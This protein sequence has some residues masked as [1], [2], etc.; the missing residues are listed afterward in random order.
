MTEDLIGVLAAALERTTHELNTL[1]D[2]TESTQDRAGKLLAHARTGVDADAKLPEQLEQ[3][4]DELAAWQL[5]DARIVGARTRA[6]ARAAL[7]DV[8]AA[9]VKRARAS[10]KGLRA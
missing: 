10:H 2:M 1:A 9:K 4:L 3:D 7:H 8:D 5:S 6:K